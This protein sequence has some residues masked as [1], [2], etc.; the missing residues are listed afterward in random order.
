MVNNKSYVTSATKT[1]FQVMRSKPK[2]DTTF[3]AKVALK[4]LEEEKTLPEL[5]KRFN[6][7]PSKITEREENIMNNSKVMDVSVIIVNY[8]TKN[9]TSNCIQ[10][11]IDKTLNVTYEIILVDNGST[12]GSKELFEH[13][14][15]IK[16]I[17]SDKNGGFGYGNNL[18]MKFAKGKYLFL[19]NS[20]TLLHNNAI[21]EF[22][23]FA[24]SHNF[25]RIYCCY[26]TGEDGNYACSFF[27]FPAFSL[28]EFLKRILHLKTYVPID[29]QNKEIECAS[30]ADMFF[31]K[32]AIEQV[33]QFDERIFLYGEEGELQYRMRK[34]GYRG[35]ILNT[36]KIQHLEGK[37]STPSLW[38]QGIKI[39]S[40]FIILK[41][42]MNYFTYLLA[43][44]YY[45]LNL[46]LRNIGCL[47]NAEGRQYLKIL[48]SKV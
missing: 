8:N 19:L 14:L 17:Y 15:R 48:I 6:V 41:T 25:K 18:G 21:K 10:S 32:K 24:E 23:D 11:I 5:A 36:P 12:D 42:H 4:T 27:D 26:L 28:K 22:F 29:Y 35:Y 34:E 46:G 13:D 45:T 30:G 20:D 40:H 39:K 31:P 44:I 16:Y 2:Y 3:K 7:A 43:R 37:S 9:L 47:F 33:G 1:L 38:K